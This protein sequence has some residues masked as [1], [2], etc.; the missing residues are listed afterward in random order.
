M[1]QKQFKAES[2]KI[3]DMMHNITVIQETYVKEELQ[4]YLGYK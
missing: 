4:R 3:L 1:K 2:K